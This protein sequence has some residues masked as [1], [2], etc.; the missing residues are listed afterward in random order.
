MEGSVKDIGQLTGKVLIFGGAYSNLQALRELKSIAEEFGIPSRNVVNT[1]DAVGYC[2]QPQECLDLIKEWGIHSIA[3]NVEMQIRNGEEDCG[4]N[5][6]EESRC[7][8]FSR[9]WYPYAFSN[10]SEESKNWLHEW[11]DFIRFHYAGKSVFVLHGSYFNTSEFIF[12]ST[13]WE[14]KEMNFYTTR[15]DVILSGHCGLPFHDVQAE[16][17]WLNA[18]V[19]GMP[20][21]DGTTRV[22]YMI[23]GDAKGFQF[24]HESFEYDHYTA[25]QLM[26]E[27]NLP[28][29]YAKTL[30]TGLWDNCEILPEV[31][32]GEMGKRIDSILQFG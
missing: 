20:A 1:G 19:I 28:A 14:V 25:A 13:P 17:Y 15:A 16:K 26:K 5:F 4:C 22:W 10:V 23:L 2:A 30:T 11:P 9:Q 6:N 3:G 21:N 31:E 8:V 32:T 12:R 29:S 18:G 24:S 7:D 27:N